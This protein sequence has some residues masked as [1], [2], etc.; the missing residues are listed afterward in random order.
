MACW[1]LEATKNKR[2]DRDRRYRLGFCF[3]AEEAR[4]RKLQCRRYLS[5]QLLPF[6]PPA[7]LVYNRVGRTPLHHGAHP[8]HSP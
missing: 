4:Y 8:E 6:H 7:A 1:D 5:P 2:A 3:P